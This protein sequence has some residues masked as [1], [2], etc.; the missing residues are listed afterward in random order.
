MDA[1]VSLLAG[2]GGLLVRAVLVFNRVGGGCDRTGIVSGPADAC[3][4]V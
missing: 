2:L 3:L 1:W 4:R